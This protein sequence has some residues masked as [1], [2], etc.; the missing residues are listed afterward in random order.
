MFGLVR[1]EDPA[2]DALAA[3]PMWSSKVD[4]GILAAEAH[5]P[6]MQLLDH[7]CCPEL[8]TSVRKGA[9]EHFLFSD[10]LRSIRID[11]EFGP[12]MAASEAPR[13]R[14]AGLASI[15]PQLLAL[16]QL[17]A[18]HRHGKFARSLH[19]AQ[20]RGPRWTQMLRVHDA[21]AQGASYREIVAVLFGVDVT[22]ARWRAEA[23]TWRLR[24]QRLAAGAASAVAAGPP[25][26]FA[27]MRR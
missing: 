26:W 9:C 18:L 3:R 5:L 23:G 10:G 20:R 24:A 6:A 25:A 7:V 4:A 15:E 21:L 13:W 16:R 14:I 12:M 8:V 1:A 2:L 22:G 11:L 19:P 27:G 17:S